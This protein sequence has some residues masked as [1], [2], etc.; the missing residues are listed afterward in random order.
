[1][2][3]DITWSFWRPC[4]CHIASALSLAEGLNVQQFSSSDFSFLFPPAGLHLRLMEAHQ[5]LALDVPPY[6][7]PCDRRSAVPRDG[8]VVSQLSL[9]LPPPLPLFQ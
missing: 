7:D 3:E 2:I 6:F 1:M 9:S 8:G 4:P 5:S